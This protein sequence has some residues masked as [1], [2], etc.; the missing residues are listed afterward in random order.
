MQWSISVPGICLWWRE[1]KTADRIMKNNC[2]VAKICHSKQKFKNVM[3]VQYLKVSTL[4]G[5]IYP[6]IQETDHSPLS[7][8]L[9]L[10]T[11]H[12]ST[13]STF[14]SRRSIQQKCEIGEFCLN[15]TFIFLAFSLLVSE[16][17]F[18][19]ANPSGLSFFRF[20]LSYE[21]IKHRIRPLSP[22]WPC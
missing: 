16:K 22:I 12:P 18:R 6:K 19:I 13:S 15:V 9:N 1:K 14:P 11:M 4:A 7:N 3:K 10:P 17:F 8:D 21:V 20:S 2:L 5:L